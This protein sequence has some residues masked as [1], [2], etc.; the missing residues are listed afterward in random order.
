MVDLSGSQNDFISDDPQAVR[1]FLEA[2]DVHEF[3]TSSSVDF[4]EE[5]GMSQSKVDQLFRK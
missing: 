3:S 5:Y 1:D 4:P 2:N